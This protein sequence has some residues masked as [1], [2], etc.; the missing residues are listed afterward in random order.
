MVTG[1]SI[2]ALLR[3]SGREIFFHMRE[4]I[5]AAQCQTCEV[6]NQC[7]VVL[8]GNVGNLSGI[9]NFDIRYAQSCIL[10]P[11]DFPFAHDGI[12][13][14]STPNTEMVLFADLRLEDLA[15]ARNRGTVQNLKDRRHDLYQTRWPS[16]G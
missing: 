11:C 9:N 5:A 16:R 1:R 15:R 12:A 10:T 8:S 7:Y 6:E 14:D 3:G 13:A 2:A 4:R